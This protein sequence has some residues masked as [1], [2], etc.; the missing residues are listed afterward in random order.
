MTRRTEKAVTLKPNSVGPRTAPE[1][2]GG[3]SRASQRELTELA[4]QRDNERPKGWQPP[5]FPS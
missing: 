2:R 1:Y 4:D 5:E 3:A